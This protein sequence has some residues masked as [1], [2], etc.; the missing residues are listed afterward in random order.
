[1]EP[2]NYIGIVL[3]AIGTSLIPIGWMYSP[4]TTLIGFIIF[5]LGLIIFMTQK[6]IE[7]I[8]DREFSSSARSGQELPADI[9]DHSG[10]GH[11]GRSTG[12]EYSHSD[13]GEGDG[14]GGGD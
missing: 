13:F 2:R 5:L 1:M 6:Y 3:V 11:G 14:D 8:E 12:W 9:N 10:W 7:K 4:T